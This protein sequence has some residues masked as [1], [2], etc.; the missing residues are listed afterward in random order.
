LEIL[1][2]TSNVCFGSP[3]I[4]E[5]KNYYNG[6]Y[7]Q[8]KEFI[9]NNVSI[10]EESVVTFDGVPGPQSGSYVELF[11][12]INPAQFSPPAILPYMTYVAPT[13]NNLNHNSLTS[14]GV[15]L[16]ANIAS[17]GDPLPV[18]ARGFC[19]SKTQG[20]PTL[21]GG[22]YT[23]CV[24]SDGTLIYPFTGPF[25]KEITGLDPNT[26]YYYSAYASNSAGR[27]YVWQGSFTTQVAPPTPIVTVELI[28]NPG[29]EKNV[30]RAGETNSLG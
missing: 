9:I 15:T 4:L 17:A 1:E 10:G 18:T 14:T 29:E 25:E 3:S 5:V 28:K 30:V 6:N 8:S 19:Y 11:K 2:E 7:I 12:P 26:F 21:P 23:T 24:S 20:F 16:T 13:V 22:T 27:G